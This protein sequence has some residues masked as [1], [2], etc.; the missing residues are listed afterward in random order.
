MSAKSPK[1]PKLAREIRKHYDEAAQE[2]ERL[3]SHSGQLEFYRTKEIISRYVPKKPRVVLDVGGGPGRYARWLAKLGHRVNL[4]D[5]VA[6][7]IEQARAAAE[8]KPGKPLA[9][10]TVGDA[11]DLEHANKSADVVLLL[12][13]LYH[14]V[15]RGDRVKALTEA[16]R[17]L[18]PGGLLF[19]AAISRFASAFD[20]LFRG[21]A[22]DDKFF[23]IVQRDLKGG[24]HRNP[25]NDP[26]YFTTAFFHH[27]NELRREIQDAGFAAP[28]VYGLEGPAWMLANFERYWSDRK[29]RARMLTIVRALEAEPTL[30]GQSAHILAVARKPYRKLLRSR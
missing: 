18:K 23:R 27:P 8:S 24:Q 6:L 7:H 20:G 22:K 19:A 12:G 3:G 4:V 1:S 30:A 29:L 5:P 15:K 13:P 26:R 25:T 16:Y 10:A 11:R 9:S 17:V 28:R 2:A 21:F 14:L